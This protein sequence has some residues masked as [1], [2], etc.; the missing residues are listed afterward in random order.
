MSATNGL[1]FSLRSRSGLI[2]CC[3]ALVL[4]ASALLAS[5]A[6]AITV[7]KPTAYVAIGDSLAFGYTQEKFDLNL[8]TENPANFEGGYPNVVAKKL[9]GPEKHAGN[10]LHLINL[11]C[12]GETSDGIVGHALGNPG[13]EYNPCGYHNLAG[14]PLH[15]PFGGASELEAAIGAVSNPG[16]PVKLISINI[17]SNDELETVGKCENPAYDAEQGFAGGLFECITV[18]AGLGG[19]EY[20]G[21]LFTHI[22]TNIATT[23]GVLRAYGYAG[24]FVIVGFYNPQAELLPG[25]DALQKK[26]NETFEFENLSKAIEYAPGKFGPEVFGPGVKYANPFGTFNPQNKNEPARICELTEECNA[27]DK[28]VNLEAITKAPVSVAEAAAYPVGDIHPT[29]LGYEKLG[30]LVYNNK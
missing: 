23:I 13:P 4:L 2:G 29:P 8:P 5:S 7:L 9:V 18:E 16:M 21:G 19:H 1:A 17:G 22:I 12:P 24:D 20:P 15:V 28:K 11:G 27:F 3:M 26:L 6:G 30:K 25:S 10:A 14:F